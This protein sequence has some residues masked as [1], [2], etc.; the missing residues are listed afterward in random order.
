MT[1]RPIIYIAGLTPGNAI[2][3]KPDREGTMVAIMDFEKWSSGKNRAESI[4][5]TGLGDENG[6]FTYT[7]DEGEALPEKIR[8]HIRE[9]GFHYLG[10][11]AELDTDGFFYAVRLEPDPHISEDFLR[12][13]YPNSPRDTWDTEKEFLR[14]QKLVSDA[15]LAHHQNQLASIQVAPQEKEPDDRPCV[16][17]SYSH[18]NDEHQ[19]W[20]EELA[21]NLIRMGVKVKADF[22]ELY[23]GKSL[24]QFM[25]ELTDQDKVLI[26]ATEKY[27]N[28]A[29]S[30]EG[31][32]GYEYSIMSNGFLKQQNASQLI[33]ILKNGS[34]DTSIPEAIGHVVYIDFRTYDNYD[35]SLELLVKAI[36]GKPQREMPPL[37]DKPSFV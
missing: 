36:Y 37:G 21:D 15:R 28:K 4:L 5:A 12:K 23:G 22:Y 6:I 32:V 11:T 17:L 19:K 13:S 10:F 29:K 3:T 1:T 25:A 18:E 14:A 8:V 30:L 31:G 35:E 26:V 9:L 34:S 27:K 20:V 16:F 24:V 33:P 2:T 7:F